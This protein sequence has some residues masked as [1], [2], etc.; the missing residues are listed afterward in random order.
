MAVNSKLSKLT[1]VRLPDEYVN[2]LERIAARDYQSVSD[3][4]RRAVRELLE[5]EASGKKK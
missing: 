1:A 5:R 2:G 3:V 4:M